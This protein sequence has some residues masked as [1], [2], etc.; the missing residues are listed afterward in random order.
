MSIHD[1]ELRIMELEERLRP[2]AD[3]PVDMTSPGWASRL[4]HRIHPLKEA[5]V[6]SRV[7]ALLEELISA[8][9]AADQAARQAM[10]KLFVEYRA[11]AWA[12]SLSTQPTTV[13]DFHQHLLL[14]SL[15][16]QERDSR[17]ALL[18][19]LDICKQARDAEVNTRPVLEQV[20]Q[21]SS[22][23]NKFGMGSTREMLLKAG[24]NAV[25]R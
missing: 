14:F 8:Y 10:R 18:W 17:D 19:L 22:E 7:E 13:A 6:R 3:R 4:K 11:F 25:N 24:Q 15:K 2:I 5:G 9:E 21:L 23:Q 1:F 16:D 12:A 20:A